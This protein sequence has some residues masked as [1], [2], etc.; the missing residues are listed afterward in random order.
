MFSHVMIGTNDIARAKHFYDAVLGTLDIA[1]GQLGERKGIQ[2]VFYRQDGNAFGVTEPIDGQPAT[3]GNGSTFAFRCSSAEQAERFH[4]TA[5]AQGGT[6]V[7]DAPGVRH[8]A[9]GDMFLAY[10]RD[11]DGHKLCAVY[12][13]ERAD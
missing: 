9:M 13:M 5:V 8:T 10:V 12:R 7:E 1:E 6:S 11:L 2:R 4:D 3:V